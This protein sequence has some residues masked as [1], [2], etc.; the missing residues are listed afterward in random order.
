MIILNI[1]YC[2]LHYFLASGNAI[3][4][5]LYSSIFSVGCSQLCQWL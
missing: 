2:Y 5:A 1:I 3:V 4:A